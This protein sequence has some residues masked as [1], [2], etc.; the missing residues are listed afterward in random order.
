MKKRIRIQI[1]GNDLNTIR[2]SLNRAGIY[3]EDIIRTGNP[4]GLVSIENGK[5]EN[6]FPEDIEAI[7]HKVTQLTIK[8]NLDEYLSHDESVFSSNIIE[9]G[10][11]V[12][13]KNSSS[14]VVVCN[15]NMLNPLLLYR[16][17]MYSD[18]FP[19]NEFSEYLKHNGAIDITYSLCFNDIKKYYD[20]YIRTTD[21]Y[22][23]KC[24]QN[25]FKKL[26]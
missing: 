12:R 10:K 25:I 23:V 2:H 18:V 26:F 1:L 24:V 5:K 4:L 14:Y 8:K 3:T 21:E 13:Y 7:N 20:K 11:T 19:N 22:H 9:C 6:V 16:N 17:Q 15:T